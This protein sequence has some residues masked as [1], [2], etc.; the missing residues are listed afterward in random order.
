MLFGAVRLADHPRAKVL[1]I[2]PGRALALEGVHR[3]VT[4]ADVPGERY[5]GLIERDWPVFVAIGE[6]TRCTGD[7]IAGVVADNQ[8]LARKAAQ[9][10]DIEYE[11]LEP[12]TDPNEALKPGAPLVHPERGT[13]LL[14][15]SV[16]KRGDVDEAFRRSAHVIEDTYYT[17][18]IEHLF[19]EPEACIAMPMVRSC[20]CRGAIQLRRERIL[21]P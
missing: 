4:A 16:L 12:V 3:V 5:V 6:E 17:Q 11:V 14:S 18:R 10:I 21:T 20:G 13:N 15:K 2:D 1:A 9:L 8:R 19:L 7:I